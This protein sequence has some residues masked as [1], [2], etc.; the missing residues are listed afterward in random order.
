LTQYYHDLVTQKSWQLLQDLKQ[1]YK[2]VLIGGWAVFL[3]TKALKSKDIDF[4]LDYPE[5]EKLREAFLVTKNER[6]KK[7]EIKTEGI[8][9]DIYLPFYS[10]LGLPAEKVSEHTL[11]LEGFKVPEVEILAILKAKAL[12]ERKGSL[13]GKKD[14]I[15]LVGLFGLDV[16]NFEK[17]TEYA[18]KYQTTESL[19]ALAQEVRQASGIE[20]LGLNVHQMARLKKKILS[21]LLFK[22]TTG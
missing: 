21:Q 13:K 9:I 22:Q 5:L 18:E 1:K 19:A 10:E 11:F 12:Q 15:D 7:Y 20:E 6:L 14:L 4:V 2:F 8:D 17:L 16:F 3:Y